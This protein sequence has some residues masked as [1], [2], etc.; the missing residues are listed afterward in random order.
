MTETEVKPLHTPGAILSGDAHFICN[1]GDEISLFRVNGSL[2]VY[3]SHAHG[4]WLYGENDL[5]ELI[6]EVTENK[7]YNLNRPLNQADSS[8]IVRHA[9]IVRVYMRM[10]GKGRP[11][12]G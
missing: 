9:D 8:I 12:V 4:I 2:R 11:D 7:I 6:A 3:V 10:L 5:D 1:I